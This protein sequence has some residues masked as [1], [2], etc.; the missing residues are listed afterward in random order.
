MHGQG[1][2]RLYRIPK[3]STFS[4]ILGRGVIKDVLH[5]P[6]P[7]GM[8]ADPGG[9]AVPLQITEGAFVLLY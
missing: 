7:S 5:L 9:K 4:G 1:R 8:L 3:T 6:Q 2:H